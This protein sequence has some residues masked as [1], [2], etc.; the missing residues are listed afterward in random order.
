[1]TKK[2]FYRAAVINKPSVVLIL[3]ALTG[4]TPD[5]QATQ[6][7]M[8][9]YNAPACTSCHTNG[10]FNKSTGSAGLSAFL[11]SQTPTCT[12]PQVLQGNVCV[13][14]TATP[15]SSCTAPQVLQGNVCV[16][17]DSATND[18]D[19]IFN[20]METAYPGY[21]A[22]KGAASSTA[23]GFY[24]RYYS[25]TN[26]YIATVNNT[27][28]YMGPASQN[29]VVSLGALADWLAAAIK[30]NP[31]NSAAGTGTNTATNTGTNTTTGYR[32][33]NIDDDDDDHGNGHNE[34]HHGSGHDNDD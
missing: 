23:S 10:V 30:T 7:Y 6:Q 1:M 8:D 26:A 27:V 11:A 9:Y 24:Y 31:T 20:Y 13:T 16:S 33:G 32:G 34:N 28:Y 3:L 19:R 21:F 12:S 5:V 18:S 2:L 29:K 4:M 25:A 14:P 22:P 15:V 17:P